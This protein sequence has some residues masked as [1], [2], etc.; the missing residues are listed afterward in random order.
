MT[1]FSSLAAAVNMVLI[2]I[3]AL[4]QQLPPFSSRIDL[5]EVDAVVLDGEGHVVTGLSADDFQILEDGQVMS[6]ATFVPITDDGASEK[7]GSRFVVLLLDDL[8]AEP[9][10]TTSIKAIARMFVRRM[11]P[12]DVIAVVYVNGSATTTSSDPASA[13]ASIDRFKPFGR[14]IMQNP[15]EHA[16]RTIMA[17]TDQLV[18]VRHG[19]KTLVYIG[20]ASIFNPTEVIGRQGQRSYAPQW[21]DALRAAAR[22]DCS[23]YVIDPAGLTGALYDNVRAFAEETGGTAFVNSNLFDQSVDQIWNEAGHYYLLGYRAP[24]STA[25][26]HSIAVRVKR[27]GVFVRSRHSRG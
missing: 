16:L 8:I 7:D 13:L 17:L 22:A 12:N 9:A 27:S 4:A 2:G 11:T 3:V 15:S 26:T 1:R 21:F 18:R 19:R 10:R 6:I 14:T 20:A 5:V 23:V 24:A 25:G